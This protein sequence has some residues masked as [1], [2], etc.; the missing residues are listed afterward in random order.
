MAFF[1]ERTADVQPD[2][3]SGR[4][5]AD[6]IQNP[7]TVTKDNYIQ[8][9]ADRVIEREQELGRDL[10][11]GEQ[12]AIVDAYRQLAGVDPR[13]YSVSVNGAAPIDFYQEVIQKRGRDTLSGTILDNLRISKDATLRAAEKATPA[14]LEGSRTLQLVSLAVVAGAAVFFFRNI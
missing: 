14:I 11:Q 10:S 8:I 2:Y 4:R 7:T 13:F 12:T 9:A 1:F 6:E 3:R 5:V